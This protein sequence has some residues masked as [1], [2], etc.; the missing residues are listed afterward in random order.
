MPP[1][2]YRLFMPP[3]TLS[4]PAANSTSSEQ[5]RLAFTELSIM[6]RPRSRLRGNTAYWPV[7]AS[8][9][10]NEQ[11]QH[12]VALSPD[13]VAAATVVAR[14]K[15]PLLNAVLLPLHI[16]F[17]RF[18]APLLNAVLFPLHIPFARFNAPLLNAVLFSTPHSV[19]EI[20]APLFPLHIP[21]AR[22]NAPLVNAVPFQLYIPF[23]FTRPLLSAIICRI[24]CQER[25]SDAFRRC[26]LDD[27]LDTRAAP[28]NVHCE[29]PGPSAGSGLRKLCELYRVALRACRGFP[30]MWHKACAWRHFSAYFTIS[31]S[32]QRR[33]QSLT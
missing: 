18:K 28:H 2:V 12:P 4:N 15:A 9:R 23:V 27:L 13:R 10:S 8:R 26:R 7:A 19:R 33:K 3:L 5:S 30:A 32:H 25:Y 1:P 17:A 20:Q 6:R 16:P 14:V 21:S 24:G 31:H 29:T 11:T 22:F